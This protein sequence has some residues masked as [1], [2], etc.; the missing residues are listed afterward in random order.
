M[1]R[2]NELQG[3]RDNE[4]TNSIG[5]ATAIGQLEHDLWIICCGDSERE[6]AKEKERE[7]ERQQRR[8]LGTEP[9]FVALRFDHRRLK[10]IVS[11]QAAGLLGL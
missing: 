7:R 8:E 5:S 6:R 3:T 1:F 4:Q 9:C 2:C 11:P 10:K